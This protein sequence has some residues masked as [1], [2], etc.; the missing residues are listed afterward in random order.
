[1]PHCKGM[2]LITVL[3]F[4]EI[5][6]LLSLYGLQSLSW[7]T[8]S[9]N[10][11]WQKHQLNNAAK[12][13]LQQA[14]SKLAESPSNCQIPL[15]PITK[16]IS[17]PM[18]W[19][20]SVS[21]AANTP[22][23]QY[24]YVTEVMGTDPCAY[25]EHIPSKSPKIANY[26]RITLLALRRPDSDAKIIMQSSIAEPVATDANCPGKIHFVTQGRQAL[27]ILM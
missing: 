14:E 9:A 21:C 10:H 16:L 12:I 25:I 22:M 2:A 5:F 1:M 7:E 15:T 20:Q 4:L 6:A 13:F 17:Q 11:Y 26:Y 24:Y 27:R 8:K 18:N 23:F 3:I 19:W